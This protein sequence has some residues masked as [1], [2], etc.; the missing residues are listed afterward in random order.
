MTDQRQSKSIDMKNIIKSAPKP[1]IYGLMAEF[2]NPGD[3]IT[4]AHHAHKEGFRKMDAYTPYPIEELAEAIGFHKSG[5]P[6]LVLIGGILGCLG[7]FMMQYYINVIDY[8]LNIGGRPFNSWVS[9]IPVTFETTVLLAA[10]TCVLGM[11][12]LN[13][14]PTPYHPVFNVPRFA[15]ASRDRFFLCIEAIDP[16]F[17]RDKTAQFLNDLK[18]KEVVEVAH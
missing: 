9:F 6:T 14:L 3:L 12:G 15:F 11:L 10:F 8:P 17:D 4:A 1:P 16:K 7:G 2:D 5:L 18:A 13:G